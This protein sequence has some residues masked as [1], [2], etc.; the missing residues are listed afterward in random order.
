M[1]PNL[2]FYGLGVIIIISLQKLSLQ[3]FRS[4]MFEWVLNT[5][6]LPSRQLH[7]QS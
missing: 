7:V 6:F 1:D 2:A 3:K 4:K 5:S